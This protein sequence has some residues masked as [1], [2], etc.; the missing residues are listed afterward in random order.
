LHPQKGRRVAAPDSDVDIVVVDDNPTILENLTMLLGDEYRVATFER[1][2][3]AL[4]FLRRRRTRL[5]INDL[6]MPMMNG[7]MLIQEARR[8][9]PGCQTMLM[10]AFIDPASPADRAVFE[11]YT[12]FAVAKPYTID[13]MLGM[14]A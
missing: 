13:E 5:V 3:L 2:D 1:V 14:V 8:L 9:C 11:R 7:F 10:S 4:A 6:R 12:R